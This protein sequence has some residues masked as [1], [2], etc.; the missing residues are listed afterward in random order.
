M[1]AAAFALLLGACCTP[2]VVTRSVAV[3]PPPCLTRPAP[4]APDAP[5]LS[6]AWAAYYVDLTQWIVEVESACGAHLLGAEGE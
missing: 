2:R 5:V 3:V 4:L 6:D 1:K